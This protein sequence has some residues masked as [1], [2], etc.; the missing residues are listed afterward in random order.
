M[1][2]KQKKEFVERR[3]FKRYKLEK[4]MEC[5]FGF[6]GAISDIYRVKSHNIAQAGVLIESTMKVP[7]GAVI[8]LEV[9]LDKLSGVVEVHKL[10]SYSEIEVKGKRFVRMWGKVVRVEEGAQGEYLVAVHLINK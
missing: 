5:Q 6:D 10:Q 9:E 4:S 8:S 3:R 1:T 7:L 2:D